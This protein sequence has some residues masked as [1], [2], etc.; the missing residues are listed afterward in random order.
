LPKRICIRINKNFMAIKRIGSF[1][2]PEPSAI[3]LNQI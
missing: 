3:A 2:T 1:M